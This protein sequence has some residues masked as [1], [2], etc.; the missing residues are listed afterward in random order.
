MHPSNDVAAKTAPTFWAWIN[1]KE[2]RALFVSHLVT[3][4]GVL[5]STGCQKRDK[6]EHSQ[7]SRPQV[8]R[9]IVLRKVNEGGC[10]YEV[11][12]WFGEKV[13]VG[14]RTA[15]GLRKIQLVFF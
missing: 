15:A 3:T 2:E 8:A 6:M 14:P 4:P 11:W 7:R 1:R 5:S 10:L 12:I 13:I 9:S